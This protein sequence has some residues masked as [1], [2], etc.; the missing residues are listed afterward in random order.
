MQCPRCNS[1]NDAASQF[2]WSCGTSLRAPPPR[3]AKVACP[4]CKHENVTNANFCV[5]CGKNLWRQSTGAA[6]RA[7]AAADN[8]P[9]TASVAE[10]PSVPFDA[11]PGTQHRPIPPHALADEY[12]NT[13]QA[14]PDKSRFEL[15]A[16]LIVLIAVMAGALI[17]WNHQKETRMAEIAVSSVVPLAPKPASIPTAVI[18]SLPQNYSTAVPAPP[19]PPGTMVRDNQPIENPAPPAANDNSSRAANTPVK[20]NPSKRAATTSAN[21]HSPAGL[22]QDELRAEPE[23]PP[24]VRAAEPRLPTTREKVAACKQLTLFK[25]ESCMW[26]ICNGKWGKDGCPSYDR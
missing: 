7:A 5:A 11:L 26:G 10:T 2:C 25:R 12:S 13:I 24:P 3:Q 14:E 22:T 19:T 16:G 18:E 8:A 20:R 4:F 9:D 15:A 1:E 17:W 21:A 23:A 6:L